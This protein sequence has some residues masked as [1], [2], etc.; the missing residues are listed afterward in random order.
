MTSTLNFIV[1]NR[2][3]EEEI[4]GQVTKWVENRGIASLEHVKVRITSAKQLKGRDIRED[5]GWKTVYILSD[6]LEP[7]TNF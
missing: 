1:P 4:K 3:V 6:G 2:E 7:K 5:S